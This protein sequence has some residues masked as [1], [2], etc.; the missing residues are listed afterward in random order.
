MFLILIP[1]PFPDH[2]QILTMENLSRIRIRGGRKIPAWKKNKAA[3]EKKI[4]EIKKVFLENKPATFEETSRMPDKMTWA[5]RLQSREEGQKLRQKEKMSYYKYEDDM[6]EFGLAY[7]RANW[8]QRLNCIET[9]QRR[10]AEAIPRTPDIKTILQTFQIKRM[11]SPIPETTVEEYDP[12]NPGI[13]PTYRAEAR[14][15]ISKRMQREENHREE[16]V[17]EE[18]ED[19]DADDIIEIMCSD[20]EMDLGDI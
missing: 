20:E 18:P 3:L 1:L 6:R 12:E 7:Q 2:I 19:D 9:V 15:E 13:P 8:S 17:M 4:E 16:E 14:R 10:V 11:L 5:Q